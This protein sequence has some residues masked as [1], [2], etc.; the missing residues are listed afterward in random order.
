M[1][2]IIRIFHNL[3]GCFYVVKSYAQEDARDHRAALV[4]LDK[5]TRHFILAESW[6]R[7]NGRNK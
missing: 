1:K 7:H 2:K 3:V 4:S 5:S 6:R